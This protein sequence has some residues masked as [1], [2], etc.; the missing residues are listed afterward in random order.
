MG[1]GKL[2]PKEVEELKNNPY[3][4]DVVNDKQVIYSTEF[5]KIYMKE[6]IRGRKPT[7]IF[8]AAGFDPKILGTKRIERASARWRES[9]DSGTL[10]D[11]L[12]DN[13]RKFNKYRG[14]ER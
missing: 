11:T 13:E 4:V 6:Y 2:K 8:I 5:K 14:N 3:V 9:W 12:G 7:E 10:G 1:R